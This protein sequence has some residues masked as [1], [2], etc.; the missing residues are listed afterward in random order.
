VPDPD[1]IFFQMVVSLII[2]VCPSPVPDPDD[3]FFQ[4]V[5]S[6][7]I[8]VCPSPYCLIL[9]IFFHFFK[10]GFHIRLSSLT[11]SERCSK[12]HLFDHKLPDGI[13]SITTTPHLT[14]SSNR[15]CPD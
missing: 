3:L 2:L 14:W 1:D 6:L 4:M 8:L 11:R 9:M 12:A 10:K 13:I 5:I 7:I 15:Q